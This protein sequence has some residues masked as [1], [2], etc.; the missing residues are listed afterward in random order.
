MFELPTQLEIGGK[1]H[2]IRNNGDF[3][4]V[5]DC[6]K[7]LNSTELDDIGRI[8]SSLVIF[9]SEI[10]DPD[11]VFEVFEDCYTEAV[12][13]MFWFFNCGQA[14]PGR[15]T[16]YTLVDWEKDSQLIAGA[17]NKVAGKE[18]RALEYLH[19][20]TFMGYYAE[21]HESAWSSIVSIRYKIKS[22]KKLEKEEERFKRENPEYFIWDSM[23]VQEKLDNE[24]IAEIWNST[25]EG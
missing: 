14:T 12:E 25:K 19:W 3:R 23:T 17:V 10:N 8:L 18:V 15:D 24:M 13:N 7:E 16:N 2:A 6:F 20:W 9:Y 11:D 21:I 1:L 5:L 22:G 4:M